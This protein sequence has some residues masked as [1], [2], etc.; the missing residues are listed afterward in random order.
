MRTV[1]WLSAHDSPEW[2]PPP[3]QALEDPPG[4]LAAGGDLS[5][6]RLLTAYRRGIFPWYSV[7]QPILWW[8]PDPRLVVDVALFKRARSLRKTVRQRRFEIRADTSFTRVIHACATTRRTG[9]FG[10]WITP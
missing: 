7:G 10:T 5:P 2:F 8:T 4:L 1:T 9:Q 6:E 3:E